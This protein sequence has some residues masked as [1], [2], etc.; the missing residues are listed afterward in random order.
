MSS[1]VAPS[2]WSNGAAPGLADGRR[3]LVLLEVFSWRFGMEAPPPPVRPSP[4][5]GA[6]P[7]PASAARLRRRLLPDH[8]A[9]SL[10]LRGLAPPPLP[11]PPWLAGLRPPLMCHGRAGAAGCWPGAM[12]SF[13]VLCCYCLRLIEIQSGCGCRFMGRWRG[14]SHHTLPLCCFSWK[15]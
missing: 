15:T 4:G 14:G 13:L 11:A 1:P 2:T 10:G 8:A 3:D 6:P 12:P 7:P 9:P 5:R